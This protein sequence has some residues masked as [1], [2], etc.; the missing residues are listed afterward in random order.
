MHMSIFHANFER[1]AQHATKLQ[2]LNNA[3]DI[4]KSIKCSVNGKELSP[5]FKYR[6]LFAYYRYL[7]AVRG[8]ING[9]YVQECVIV[10]TP[11]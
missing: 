2:E 4:S 3:L 7:T 8:Y 6:M 11:A 10:P 9:L 1:S 5:L